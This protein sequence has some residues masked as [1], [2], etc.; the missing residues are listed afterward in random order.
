MQPGA[1]DRERKELD[2]KVVTQARRVDIMKA[3][4]KDNPKIAEENELLEKLKRTQP[5]FEERRNHLVALISAFGKIESLKKEYLRQAESAFKRK[6]EIDVTL[7]P[8]QSRIALKEAKLREVQDDVRRAR[9]QVPFLG[10]VPG[11]GDAFAFRDEQATKSELVIFLRASIIRDAS[12]EGDY[13]RFRDALPAPDFFLRPNP[14]R[15][16]EPEPK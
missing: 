4:N 14:S 7:V 12:T 3:M 5:V 8:L 9:D 11:V 2:K 1:L 15:L 16:P 10:S 13:R 6:K